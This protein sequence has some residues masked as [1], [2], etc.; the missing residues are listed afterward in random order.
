[1][2]H[3]EGLGAVD[4]SN[5][6]GDINSVFQTLH[7][8]EPGMYV[9]RNADGSYT[10]YR[11][12][13]GNEQNLPVGYGGYGGGYGVTTPGL[14]VQGSVSTGSSGLWVLIAIGA[15]LFMFSRGR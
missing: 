14:G 3:P 11:Q 7:E 12:P 2:F 1:M 15:A 13:T 10:T 5:I 4:F 9:Q 8:N 6:T